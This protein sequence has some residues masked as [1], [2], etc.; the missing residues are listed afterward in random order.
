MY[1][2]QSRW[3][4]PMYVGQSMGPMYVGL[5]PRTA[6]APL[7]P[8]HQQPDVIYIQVLEKVDFP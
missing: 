6:H 1:V 8:C 2:G 4:G 7:V 3:T 5:V